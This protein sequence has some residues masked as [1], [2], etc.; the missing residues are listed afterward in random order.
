MKQKVTVIVVNYNSCKRWPIIEACLKGILS[1]EYRPLEI[2]IVD[3]GSTDNSLEKIKQILTKIKQDQNFRIKLIKLSKNYGFAVANLIAYKFRDRDSEYVALI[4]N[5]VYPE[6]ESL[7]KL[8]RFLEKSERIACVQGANLSWDGCHILTYGGFL[9]DHGLSGGI[10]AFIESTTISSMK[11]IAVAFV[12]GAYSVCRV[13]AIEKAGGL[14]MPYFFMWGDDYELGIR[15]WRRGFIM[16]AVP[17][18][19]SKHYSGAST[20]RDES[21][22]IFEPTRMTRTY[23]YWHWTSNI[24]VLTL[25]GYLYI[26]QLLK[27]LPTAVAFAVMKKSRIVLRG[28]IDGVKLGMELRKRLLKNEKWLRFPKEPIFR[29][30]VLHEVA[31]L[32]QLYLR[33]GYR[34][35]R[36]YYILIARSIGRKYLKQN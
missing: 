3:N 6:P 22:S 18:V 10:A 31:L 19:A 27:R 4:N 1:L 32:L 25:Y 30:N 11:P 17:I 36:L 5:D 29:T 7:G 13:D 33:F 34:A 20:N 26:F 14:F 24:A 8:I 12:D 21:S 2:I 23:E 9:T 15:M 16:V 28:F 35:S